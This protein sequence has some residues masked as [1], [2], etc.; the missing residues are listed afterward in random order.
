[1]TNKDSP[2]RIIGFCCRNAISGDEGFAGGK[3]RYQY[4]PTI[5]VISLP[6]SSKVE[7]LGIIRA[8]ESGADGIFVLGCPDGKCHLLGGNYRAQKIVDYTKGLLKEIGM[9]NSRLEMFQLG[10]G[11]WQH[12]DQVVKTMTSRIES[13]GKA[14]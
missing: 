10:T 7:T 2:L 1:M 9:K 8:F 4:E 5:K 12:F 11:Q 3:G 14:L 6:C 13:L